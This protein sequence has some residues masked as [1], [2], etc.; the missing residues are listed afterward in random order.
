[1]IQGG[2]GGKQGVDCRRRAMYPVYTGSGRQEAK[3]KE[4]RARAGGI[5][6]GARIKQEPK[7]EQEP[8]QEPEQT[9]VDHHDRTIYLQHAHWVI[10]TLGAD[11]NQTR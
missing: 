2:F 9:L 6:Q 11:A 8:G 3:G 5:E 7:P 4:Q 1:M 10:P